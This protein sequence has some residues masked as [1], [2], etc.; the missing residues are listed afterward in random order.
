[1]NYK[2]YL[3]FGLDNYYP[4]GARHDVIESF[5]SLEEVKNAIQK[6]PRSYYDILDFEERR[7]IDFEERFLH[8]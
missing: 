7:W 4:E 2:R 5:D 8:W 3:L 6:N 1:M